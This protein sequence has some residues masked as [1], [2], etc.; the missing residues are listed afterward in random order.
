MIYK[1]FIIACAIATTA[2]LQ[3]KAQTKNTEPKF[4]TIDNTEYFATYSYELQRDSLGKDSRVQTKMSLFIGKNVCKFEHNSYY[5][6]DS[7]WINFKGQNKSQYI[8]DQ[9]SGN[10]TPML[11]QY[12]IIKQRSSS[13]IDL[14]ERI[15]HKDYHFEE[16]VKFN[17]I[18]QN[19]TDTLIAGYKCKKAHTF[20]KGRKYEAWYSLDIP[21]NEGPYKFK[22]L[23]GLIIKIEDIDKEHCFEL[24]Q[25]E[26][27]N[28]NKP[29][30][31]RPRNYINIAPIDYLKLKHTESLARVKRVS[32]NRVISVS[33]GDKGI[34][35]AK[36]LRRNNFIEK[37]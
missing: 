17:W 5:T 11:A 1:C 31:R 22:G 3:S 29:I 8:I 21:I 23:P 4:K 10:Y 32:S 30:Y 19:T 12:I 15:M 18:V 2:S 36:L 27:I 7:L 20:F 33:S 26:K 13:Q 28:Y 6:M 24:M 16:K 37:Y 35:E 9:I 14:Y 34:I 25:F